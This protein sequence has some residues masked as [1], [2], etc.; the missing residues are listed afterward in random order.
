M[1]FCTFIKRFHVASAGDSTRVTVYPAGGTKLSFGELTRHAF[2]YATV[3]IVDTE[4]WDEPKEVFQVTAPSEQRFAS[5]LRS[6][7]EL[8]RRSI[9]IADDL[10]ESRALAPRALP[11]EDEDWRR[12]AMG[13]LV[14]KA[15]DYQ[16]HGAVRE[17]EAA[18]GIHDRVV[19]FIEEHPRYSRSDALV[20]APSSA[21]EKKH[22]LPRAVAEAVSKSA[23][24]R[25]LAADRI[26][27]IPAQK[28]YDAEAGGVSR[29][30]LQNGSVALRHNVEGRTII[31]LDDLY[32]TGS[33]MVEV[34]R[35]CRASGAASVLGLAFVKNAKYTYGMD[36]S[37]WPWS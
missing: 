28:E 23:G 29:S 8:N 2:P 22:T 1:P 13:E 17:I 25:L 11:G 7:L 33:T 35:A 36:L 10:D 27:S 9:A 4:W 18:T 31:V 37:E 32:E 15:K 3:S 26:R 6:F 16:G 5:R 21:P 14:Y 34:A 20:A 12:T 30:D 19:Q 24:K